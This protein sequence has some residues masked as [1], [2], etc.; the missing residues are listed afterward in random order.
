MQ[1]KATRSR[2][3]TLL[4]YW[5]EKTYACF[6]SP[7]SSVHKQ[8]FRRIICIP[9]QHLVTKMPEGGSRNIFSAES[10]H[11]APEL[12]EGINKYDSWCRPEPGITLA[13]R[14]AEYTVSRAQ[15]CLTSSVFQHGN[16]KY[17]PSSTPQ[18]HSSADR[19][20][21]STETKYQNTVIDSSLAGEEGKH[22]AEVGVLE[23]QPQGAAHLPPQWR[24]LVGVAWQS[25]GHHVQVEVA[26]WQ[27]RRWGLCSNKM[28]NGLHLC[29]TSQRPVALYGCLSF[30]HSHTNGGCCHLSSQWLNPSPGVGSALQETTMLMSPSKCVEAPTTDQFWHVAAN[31]GLNKVTLR[32]FFFNMTTNGVELLHRGLKTWHVFVCLRGPMGN[33]AVGQSS[34]HSQHGYVDALY[35][36]DR[37]LRKHSLE[38]AAEKCLTHIG[39]MLLTGDACKQ[40]PS[41]LAVVGVRCER[42][43]GPYRMGVVRKTRSQCN[44][45]YGISKRLHWICQATSCQPQVQA[46]LDTNDPRIIRMNCWSK[47]L[48]ISTN[49]TSRFNFSQRLFMRHNGQVS[50]MSGT[51]TSHHI[52]HMQGNTRVETVIWNISDVELNI[53]PEV[54]WLLSKVTIKLRVEDPMTTG[55]KWF[56]PLKSVI[57]QAIGASC[58][59]QQAAA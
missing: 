30:I 29:R 4:S 3:A 9:H 37:P 16:V 7:P 59:S 53:I 32:V 56:E 22:D 52:Y 14:A 1:A 48:T 51:N 12:P 25:H 42:R 2:T 36:M 45:V 21:R 58:Y 24:L 39:G 6:S 55:I 18:R 34:K 27:Q 49:M 38:R 41:P 31:R 33:G 10:S 20:K 15:E 5:K 17:I 44:H 57:T 13:R 28:V 46:A 35:L 47:C 8:Q 19:E 43:S 54:K 23:L 50:L 26:W 11:L 40:Q